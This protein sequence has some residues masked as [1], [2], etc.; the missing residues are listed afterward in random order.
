MTSE[1]IMTVWRIFSLTAG[2][3]R[4]VYFSVND[5]FTGN[6]LNFFVINE[7]YRNVFQWKNNIKDKTKSIYVYTDNMKQIYQHVCSNDIIHTILSD[8]FTNK[9]DEIDMV[10]IKLAVYSKS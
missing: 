7:V 6:G 3:L 1:W 5:I 8:Y 9:G 10:H 2:C 4:F